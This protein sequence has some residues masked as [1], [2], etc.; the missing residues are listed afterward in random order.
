MQ[1]LEQLGQHLF[2]VHGNW[3]TYMG[4]DLRWH[5]A[6]RETATLL[7]TMNWLKRRRAN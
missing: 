1:Y 4:V 2:F 7:L 6:S 3:F 5:V